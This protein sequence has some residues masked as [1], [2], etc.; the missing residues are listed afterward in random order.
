M[1][2]LGKLCTAKISVDRFEV[3]HYCL[4]LLFHQ[5]TIAVCIPWTTPTCEQPSASQRSNNAT[6]KDARQ[7]SWHHY[8]PPVFSCSFLKRRAKTSRGAGQNAYLGGANGVGLVVEHTP[9]I[10]FRPSPKR[11]HPAP[12]SQHHVLLSMG[13]A[14]CDSSPMWLSRRAV[15]VSKFCGSST[16]HLR[17]SRLP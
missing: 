10:E 7:V 6:L 2:G 11:P 17:R 4:C 15:V 8:A 9:S 12:A 16:N 5:Q 14:T 3:V 13:A 1:R